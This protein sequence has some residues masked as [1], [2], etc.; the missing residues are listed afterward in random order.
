MAIAVKLLRIY[1]EKT[2]IPNRFCDFFDLDK[3]ERIHTYLMKLSNNIN[4]NPGFF[5]EAI[6]NSQVYIICSGITI[7]VNSHWET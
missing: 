4:S 7:H 5:Y 1:G 2:N 6:M 3:D